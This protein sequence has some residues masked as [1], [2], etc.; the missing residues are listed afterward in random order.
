MMIHVI[1][2]AGDGVRTHD[3]DVGK[4][5]LYQL[6]Y[7]RKTE[8]ADYRRRFQAESRDYMRLHTTFKGN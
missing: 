4:V 5:L 2:R 8:A 3:N 7:T 1:Q 6:S